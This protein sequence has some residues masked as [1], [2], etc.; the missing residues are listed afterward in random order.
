MNETKF[1]KPQKARF[2]SWEKE[3]V[4]DASMDAIE[5]EA[6]ETR[7]IGSQRS[8][9]KR[10]FDYQIT[11]NFNPS[12]R[13][14]KFMLRGKIKYGT[15]GS[16][17]SF[18]LLYEWLCNAYNGGVSFIDTYFEKRF[19]RRPVGLRFERFWEN[20]EEELEEVR[21]VRDELGRFMKEELWKDEQMKREA[22][23]L[24][25][26]IKDDIVT[27]LSNGQIPL[28][29]RKGARVK[30]STRETRERFIGLSPNYLF[31]A[32]GQLIDALN[33]FVEVGAA[34]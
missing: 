30:P 34:A 26:L 33:I 16:A 28:S 29:G 9:K 8:G 2:R 22:K 27:C 10:K 4:E 3:G 25:R 14:N 13:N 5:F 17:V 11:Y 32:S 19:K 6:V 15:Y 18:R 20:I 12:M 21:P 31:F 1:Y 23:E 7:R 24:G